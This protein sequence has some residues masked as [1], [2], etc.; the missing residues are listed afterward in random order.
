MDAP[1][2]EAITMAW[3]A[4]AVFFMIAGGLTSVAVMWSRA[5]KAVKAMIAEGGKPIVAKLDMLNKTVESMSTDVRESVRQLVS[6]DGDLGRLKERVGKSEVT[7]D[8][9]AERITRIEAKA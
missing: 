6:H 8:D 4:A 1:P 5:R 2:P 9:H 3:I 7:L